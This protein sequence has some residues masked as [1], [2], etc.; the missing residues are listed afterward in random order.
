MIT[1]RD[2]KLLAVVL[3]TPL[4]FLPA[5]YYLKSLSSSAVYE[6]SVVILYFGQAHNNLPKQA[7]IAVALLDYAKNK[8]KDLTALTAEELED[9]IRGKSLNLIKHLERAR[10]EEG[11][12]SQTLDFPILSPE[13][14]EAIAKLFRDEGYPVLVSTFKL[15]DGQYE[16]ISETLLMKGDREGYTMMQPVKEAK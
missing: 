5:F 13:Q 7:D 4:F 16:Q 12:R 14:T 1:K 3:W 11:A 9:A 15:N 2:I 8:G 6:K 10:L